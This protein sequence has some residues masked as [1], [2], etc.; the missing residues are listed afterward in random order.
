MLSL[1]FW[2]LLIVGLVALLLRSFWKLDDE[3]PIFKASTFLKHPLIQKLS[4]F[5]RKPLVNFLLQALVVLIVTRLLIFTGWTVCTLI[6]P[7]PPFWDFKWFYVASKLSHHHLSPFNVEIFTDYFCRFTG[8]CGFI[9]PFVYPPNILP[10]LWPLGY[11]SINTAFTIWTVIHLL[12]IGFIIWGANILLDSKSRAFRGVCTIMCALIHGIVHDL[13]VGNLSSFL[14]AILIWTVILAKRGRNAP[15]GV[16]LGI[17]AIKP[18]LSILFIPYF[19][20]KKRF[21]LVL[22]CIATTLVLASIGLII[23]GSSVTGFL[24]DSIQGFPLWL[25]DPPNNPFLSP[26]RI[27]LR[28]IGPRFLPGSPRIAKITSDLIVAVLVGGISAYL[29]KKQASSSWSSNIYLSEVTLIFCLSISINYSQQTNSV[30]LIPAVVFLLN[31]LLFEIKHSQFSWMRMSLW[32]SGIFCLIA[33]TGLIYHWLLEPL[34]AAWNKGSLPYILKITIGSVP[35][36]ALLVLTVN[37]LG[38][39]AIDLRKKHSSAIETS[40]TRM[41]GN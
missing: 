40:A 32:L 15:A 6:R 28:V 20:L 35:N 12:I 37:I 18:T 10:L 11:F 13:R 9:P 24:Q 1:G 29:Y 4:R 25:Q 41:Q 23:A 17:A 33:H 38:L 2:N 26:S 36:Y 39:A 30:M 7:I 16:L 31:Y 34:G 27:D 8:V 14:A 21:S 19:L 3:K 5:C 22:W